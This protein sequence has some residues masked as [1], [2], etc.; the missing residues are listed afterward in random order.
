MLL[1]CLLLDYSLF[2]C[3]HDPWL[4]YLESG[5]Q[6]WRIYRWFSMQKI[7]LDACMKYRSWSAKA[8]KSFFRLRSFSWALFR[9]YR[10][11]GGMSFLSNQKKKTVKSNRY[12]WSL[13]QTVMISVSGCLWLRP[14]SVGKH[15]QAS[16][17]VQMGPANPS[18]HWEI[19][20]WTHSGSSP[21]MKILAAGFWNMAFDKIQSSWSLDLEVFRGFTE[22]L[23][24][25]KRRQ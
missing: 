1:I 2:C 4:K 16:Q 24:T 3:A 17:Y 15:L 14:I 18:E 23:S 5:G 21:R 8:S 10:S 13:L 9:W 20:L 7:A 6:R 22:G 25:P 12:S 19:T 11:F